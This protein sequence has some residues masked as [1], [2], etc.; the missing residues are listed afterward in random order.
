M[1]GCVSGSITRIGTASWL[2]LWSD[3]WEYEGYG[4][5]KGIDAR[6]INK[7]YTLTVDE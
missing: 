3:I 6:Y 1:G 4:G 2:M 5:R 7:G